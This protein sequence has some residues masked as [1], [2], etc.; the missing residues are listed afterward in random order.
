MTYQYHPGSS[1][2]KFALEVNDVLVENFCRTYFV[3]GAV[4]DMLL[5]RKIYDIDI[6]TSAK[7]GQIEKI[8]R[9]KNIRCDARNSRYG[10][11]VAKRSAGTVEITTFRQ[12]LPSANRYPEVR[13]LNSPKPD[14][15]RRDFTINALYY[16]I[17]TGKIYDF[18]DGLRDLEKRQ[19]RF[20][21]DPAQRIAQ[22]P[23][24]I[25]RALRFRVQLNFSLHRE[26]EAAIKKYSFLIKKLSTTRIETEILKLRSEKQRKILRRIINSLPL[27]VK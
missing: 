25:I 21:G 3:G 19:L 1:Y 15:Q 20:I 14:S 22:D 13:L 26:T 9:E 18:Q 23:L 10:V 5:H 17:K 6:A 11:I 27:D 4:R 24:R 7:P 2:E 12:D 16:E 8:L